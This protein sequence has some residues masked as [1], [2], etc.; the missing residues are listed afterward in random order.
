MWLV[1]GSW[2]VRNAFSLFKTAFGADG[3]QRS[4]VES[5]RC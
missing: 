2:K 1:L 4:C 5:C 3:E